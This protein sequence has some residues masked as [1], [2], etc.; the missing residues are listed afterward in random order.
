[1]RLMTGRWIRQLAMPVCAVILTSGYL[2]TANAAAP[3]VARRAVFERYLDFASL[4]QV[5]PRQRGWMPDGSSLWY[6]D[7]NPTDLAIRRVDPIANTEMPLFDVARLRGE[8]SKQL[9]YELPGQG[10][11]FSR[12]GFSGPQT[13]QFSYSGT[14]YALDL[15]D[16]RLRVLETP[17]PSVGAWMVGERERMTPR[18]FRKESFLLVGEVDYPESRSPDGKWFASVKGMDLSLRSTYDG[19]ELPLT[20]DGVSTLRWDVETVRSQPWSPDST[21]LAAFRIDSKGVDSVPQVHWLNPR[22][23]VVQVPITRAGGVLP[24]YELYIIDVL[25]RTPRKVE[26]GDTTNQYLT[27]LGWCPQ[28]TELLVARWDRDFKKVEVVAANPRTGAARTVFSET[29]QTFVRLQHEVLYMGKS[30]FTLL[31]DGKRFIWESTRSG[32]NQL[33]LYS[34]D[35][36]LIRPLTRGEFP[37]LQVQTIDAE[38]GW[39]YFTAH[40]E[41]RLY[42]THLYRVRLNGDDFSRLTQGDGQHQ[43]EF[44]PSKR[45]FIDTHSSVDRAPTVELRSAEGRLV[46]RIGEANVEELQQ[47]GW[48]EPEEFVVKAADGQTDLYGVLYK[49]YDFDPHKK[50]PVVEYIYGGPQATV[51]RRDF[52]VDNSKLSNLPRA[53]AQLGYLTVMLDARGTPGRSKAF[54]DVVYRNWGR[55]EILDHAAALKQLAAA[56]PYVDLQ[57]VGI[58][59]ASWGGYFTFRALT[60]APEIYKAGISMMPGFDPYES[61]LYEPYLGLPADG[62]AA[63]D[64]AVP[65]KWAELLQGN[66]L[67]VASTSD[68]G[69]F[70]DAIRMAEA[71]IRAGKQHEFLV[72]PNQPHGALGKSEDFLIE[73]IVDFFARHLQRAPHEE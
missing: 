67:L 33:Y 46:R 32:W 8:L 65:F 4:V 41:S 40:A 49:P 70:G 28:G 26:L 39:V 54:Q 62:R 16:Y 53:L 24:K 1:M 11:P 31:P 38:Q 10:V 5:R 51:T 34:I 30:G 22:S 63:Y 2:H 19:R 72:L 3:D 6:A 61:I 14:E 48:T 71:L 27:L 18:M 57:R 43:V 35:G 37:V 66:L 23:D 55:N 64:Y 15:Q 47:V 60:Q 68:H 25:S 36:K 12:F 17:A 73:A 13:I 44:A 29:S 42:D 21:Y 69:T 45:F 58:Y 50:Y 52:S 7:G 9:G 56:R 20:E 59:G